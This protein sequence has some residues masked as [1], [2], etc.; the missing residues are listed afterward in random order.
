M[1]S[2]LKADEEVCYLGEKKPTYPSVVERY[3]TLRYKTGSQRS[4]YNFLLYFSIVDKHIQCTSF[5]PWCVGSMCGWKHHGGTC[6][7]NIRN[8]YKVIINKYM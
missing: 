4:Y 1:A 6:I 2:P 8:M 7:A 3:Y 5:R